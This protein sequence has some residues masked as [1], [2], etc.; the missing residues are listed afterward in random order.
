MHTFAKLTIAASALAGASLA[1]PASASTIIGDTIEC[2]QVGSGSN[3]TC[4]P[5]SAN[6]DM[7]TEFT[8]GNSTAQFL[9]FDFDANSLVMTSLVT[10]NLGATIIEF[11]NLTN[12]F[13]VATITGQTGFSGFTQSDVSIT[14]GVLSLNLADTSNPAGSAVTFSLGAGAIPEPETWALMLLGF[15][16]TGFA[17][18]HAKASKRKVS[19]A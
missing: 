18:R 2:E 19:F 9:S 5:G 12:P 11:A 10:N 3:F 17:M 13:T 8:A 15:F 7:T 16:A 4:T 6:V 1:A 14:N